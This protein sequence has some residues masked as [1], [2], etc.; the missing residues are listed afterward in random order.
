MIYKLHNAEEA[1]H[2]LHFISTAG[3]SALEKTF[4]QLIFGGL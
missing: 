1:A 2:A 3:S 4:D